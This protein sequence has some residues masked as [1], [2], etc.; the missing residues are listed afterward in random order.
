MNRCPHCDKPSKDPAQW[1]NGVKAHWHAPC[2]EQMKQQVIEEMFGKS[3]PKDGKVN[4]K[5]K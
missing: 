5:G 2:F 4:A 3:K 1:Y